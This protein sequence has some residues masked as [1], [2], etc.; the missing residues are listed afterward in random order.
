MNLADML[1]YADIHQ[2]NKIA[3]HYQCECSGNSKNELIQAILNAVSRN[4][5]FNQFIGDMTIEDIR[6]LNSMLFENRASYSLED[7]TARASQ[8]RLSPVVGNRDLSRE[9]IS[10]FKQK[11]WLFNGYSHDTKF[12]F[13]VPDDLKERTCIAL[14]GRFLTNLERVDEPPAYRDEQNV[15]A[16]DIMYLLRFLAQE[17]V[18]LTTDGAI[19][20]RVLS[21]L[22]DGMT[23]K[24]L[25]LSRVGWRFGYG[26]RFRD[27]PDR[28]SFIY[29]YCYYNEFIREQD[30]QLQLTEKGRRLVHENHKEDLGQMYRLWIRLYKGPVPN[31]LSLAHWVQRLSNRWV[32]ASSLIATLSPM[33]KPFYYDNAETI[34]EQRILQMM[35]HLGLIRMGENVTGKVVQATQIALSAIR[36]VKV[37]DEEVI[38]FP[39]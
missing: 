12:D 4:E 2:L 14:Q 11:G 30:D 23:V 29:D 37:S 28:F 26:R 31:I 1:C 32:T 17:D 38:T 6:F 36:G 19:Y 34:V 18:P 21:Q 33:V 9:M 15:L 25:P 27:Y 20:K 7:L 16:D 3:Q 13:Q 24:E 10:S 35:M 8:A 22:L 39:I 5:S